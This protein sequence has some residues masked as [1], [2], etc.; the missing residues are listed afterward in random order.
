MYKTILKYLAHKCKKKYIFQNIK[1]S[2][3]DN[4]AKHVNAC[5]EL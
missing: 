2:T 5:Y 3:T 1:I 4:I